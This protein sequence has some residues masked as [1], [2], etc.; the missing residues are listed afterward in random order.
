MD[1][2]C[3]VVLG[4]ADGEHRRRMRE[5]LREFRDLALRET[6]ATGEETV[7]AVLRHEPEILFL[8]VEF[9]EFD[10]FELLGRW[11][12]SPFPLVTV[13]SEDPA[14]AH[15][16]FRVEAFD[17]L[18]APVTVDELRPCVDRLRTEVARRRTGFELARQVAFL[19]TGWT[20]GGLGRLDGG[21]PGS[22]DSLLAGRSD[23]AGAGSGDPRPLAREEGP[24]DEHEGDSGPRPNGTRE[25]AGR[26]GVMVKTS[27]RRVLLDYEE[28]RWIEA[29]DY[30]QRIHTTDG[31][32]LIRRS[33][34]ELAEDLAPHGF[35]R[36]HRSSIVNGRWI[37][38][39]RPEGDGRH[40]V[41]L[42]DGTEL[43]LTRSHRHV[44]DEILDRAI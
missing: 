12:P 21:S 43:S 20:S 36:I 14:D 2:A 27:G 42:K 3:A 44:V 11:R 9:P 24:E 26:T 10:P 35:H 34:K 32:Y 28:I 1:E 5:A 8:G 38:E 30:Y 22:L 29:V 39:I 17:F 15:Q 31:S 25:S 16:A 7:R 18:R 23:D 4:E 33:M 19:A 41:H 13:V 40:R 37:R 6:C